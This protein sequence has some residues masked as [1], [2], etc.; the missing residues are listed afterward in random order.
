MCTCIIIALHVH[1]SNRSWVSV[2]TIKRPN[3]EN[4]EQMYIF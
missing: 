2:F 1:N 3:G 4:T